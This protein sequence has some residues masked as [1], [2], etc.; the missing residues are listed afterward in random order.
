MPGTPRFI[1]NDL[2]NI[3]GILMAIGILAAAIWGIIFAGSIIESA[4]N[5]QVMRTGSGVSGRTAP[6]FYALGLVFACVIAGWIWRVL[7]RALA[8]IIR[9]LRKLNSN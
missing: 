7:F 3:G 8:E 5:N 2:E 9:Q 1:E 4:T 6:D